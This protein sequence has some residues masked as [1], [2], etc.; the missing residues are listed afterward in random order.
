MGVIKNKNITYKDCSDLP[1]FNFDKI[2]TE[3]NFMWLVRGYD[4]YE[5]VSIPP[6]AD[7]LYGVILNEYCELTGSNKMMQY[8]ELVVEISRLEV[9][10]LTVYALLESMPKE[11]GDLKQ[12]IIKEL[13]HWGFYYKSNKNTTKEMKR[14]YRQLK[15]AKTKIDRKKQDLKKFDVESE[16]VDLIDQKLSLE[17]V[18]EKNRIDLKKISVKEWVK[19]NNQANDIIRFRRKKSA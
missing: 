9:R 5:D 7:D 16:G 6:N 2:R 18:L 14:L 8:Y 3:G 17:R 12:G 15:A 4:G 11:D 13:A 1:I 10:S 19:M